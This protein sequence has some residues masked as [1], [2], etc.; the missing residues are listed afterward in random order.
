MPSSISMLP[1]RCARPSTSRTT[2]PQSGRSHSGDD[3][4]SCIDGDTDDGVGPVDE[5]LTREHPLTF[6]L[7]DIVPRLRRR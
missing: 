1:S 3:R 2:C 6:S 7:G 5:L 4:E